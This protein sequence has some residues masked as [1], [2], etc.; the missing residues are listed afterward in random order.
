[1]GPTI[2]AVSRCHCIQDFMQLCSDMRTCHGI[3]L[4]N[5]AMKRR[6]I[7]GN[8]SASEFARSLYRDSRC[9]VVAAKAKRHWSDGFARDPSVELPLRFI[10]RTQS[11]HGAHPRGAAREPA[12]CGATSRIV[13]E[14][15]CRELPCA[16]PW[17]SPWCGCK[18][19]ALCSGGRTGLSEVTVGAALRRADRNLL[20]TRRRAGNPSSS[21]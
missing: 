17:P 13:V 4:V 7:V 21:G 9:A 3:P 2:L 14:M 20:G 8:R 6:L 10:V 15:A 11:R 1:V 19:V 5:C 16:M 12:T 18:R